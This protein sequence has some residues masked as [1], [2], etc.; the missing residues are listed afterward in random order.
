M[1]IEYSIM[2]DKRIEDPDWLP[3]PA[4]APEPGIE[5][6]RLAIDTHVNIVARSKD[7]MTRPPWPVTWR[8]PCRPGR[9]MPRPLSPGA[10]P[11]G[12]I[13]L[14]SWKRCSSGSDRSRQSR[15]SLQS[16]Q[17]LR[18]RRRNAQRLDGI[19]AKARQ[20]INAMRLQFDTFFATAPATLTPPVRYAC[21]TLRGA[22]YALASTYH[23]PV[24]LA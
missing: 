10:I 23:P 3:P 5:D 22:W 1:R 18:G 12:S 6:Y 16:C 20:M 21:A 9:Q 19:T 7:T 13:P 11:S 14:P 15:T 4:P 17:S 8:A 24:A 2:T